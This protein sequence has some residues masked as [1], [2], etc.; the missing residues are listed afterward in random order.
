MAETATA[1]TTL[2][3]LGKADFAA[4]GVGPTV[5]RASV[6]LGFSG[7]QQVQ[8]NTVSRSHDRLTCREAVCHSDSNVLSKEGLECALIL[9][10]RG[11][12]YR[13]I[14]DSVLKNALECHI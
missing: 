12:C 1:M 14:D 11:V 8:C 3:A 4:L 2:T 10:A 9:Q 13:A 7:L 5:G 6:V